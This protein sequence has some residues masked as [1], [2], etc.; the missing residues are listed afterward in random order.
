[1]N[2]YLQDRGLWLVPKAQIGPGE[3]LVLDSHCTV[4]SI[5]SQFHLNTQTNSQT[6]GISL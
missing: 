6:K 5:I 2:E 3:C 4:V 1:M